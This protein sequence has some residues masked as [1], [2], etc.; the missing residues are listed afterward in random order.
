MLNA[1][2]DVGPLP[3]GRAR[4]S[5]LC[6]RSLSE[7]HDAIAAHTREAT[8]RFEGERGYRPRTGSSSGSRPRRGPHFGRSLRVAAQPMQ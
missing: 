8:E 5:P 6:G 1:F 2:G 7:R 3:E 4:P